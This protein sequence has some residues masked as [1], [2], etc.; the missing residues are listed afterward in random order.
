MEIRTMNANDNTYA[1]KHQCQQTPT[2]TPTNIGDM[3]SGDDNTG[4]TMSMRTT[5]QGQQTPGNERGQ[6]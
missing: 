5:M 1:N 2:P 4:T 3:N 6:Q